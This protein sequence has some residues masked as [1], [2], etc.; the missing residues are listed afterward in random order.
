MDNILWQC[1]D[2][3]SSHCHM[4]TLSPSKLITLLQ[5]DLCRQHARVVL[6][7][8]MTNNTSKTGSH[9]SGA[10]LTLMIAW[11]SSSSTRP[12]TY[13][14]WN[15]LVNTKWCVSTRDD[16]F[17]IC[18]QSKMCKICKHVLAPMYTH[19]NLAKVTAPLA[20]LAHF[21]QLI[22]APLWVLW[23]AH[24]EI[25]RPGVYLS[26]F[27]ARCNKG[28]FWL[29]WVYWS[30]YAMWRARGSPSRVAM[31]RL[32]MLIMPSWWPT[33]TLTGLWA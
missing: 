14:K 23:H 15:T 3:T 24:H 32:Y 2:S 4:C 26:H 12:L 9:T 20:A 8:N 18:F 27:C 19:Y 17:V 7:H 16:I 5:Q 25:M 10:S 29:W 33:R 11:T 31:I 6:L 13:F 1:I 22:C 30:I 28:H 21:R